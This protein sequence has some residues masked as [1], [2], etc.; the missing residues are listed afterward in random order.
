VA[1]LLSGDAQ[2]IQ[3][4]EPADWDRIDQSGVAKVQSTESV[5][6]NFLLIRMWKEP[7]DDARVRRALFHAIDIESL[8][9]QLMSG[10]AMPA[11]AHISTEVFGYKA[12]PTYGYDPEEARDLLAEAG[13][14]D[15][16]TVTCISS[17]TS[18][19]KSQ[20]VLTAIQAMAAPAGFN[21]QLNLMEHGTWVESLFAGEGELSYN[22]YTPVNADAGLALSEIYTWPSSET[23]WT[24]YKGID[25]LMEQAATTV[26]Q[27]E[28]EGIFHQVLDKMWEDLPSIPIFQINSNRGVAANLV[29]FPSDPL[30][31]WAVTYDTDLQ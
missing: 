25:D 11:T 26:D 4:P 28:R 24:G 3:E 9:D 5:T 2:I 31:L 16:V 6:T 18:P 20:E 21:I 27:E 13:Y 1:A 15:G 7:F 29:N 17:E 30:G 10:V 23:R 8:V 14:P 22:P 12:E 19:P